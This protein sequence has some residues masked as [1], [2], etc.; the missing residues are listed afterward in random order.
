MGNNMRK[1][2]LLVAVT[3]VILAAG[4]KGPAKK[5]GEEISYPIA[6]IT[7]EKADIGTVIPAS[8]KGKQD[9]EIRPKVNGYIVKLCVDEGSVVRRGQVLFQLDPVSYQEAVAAAEALIKT[10]EANVSSLQLTVENKRILAQRNVISDMELKA[11]EYSM[12]SAE[13][14]LAQ[15]K[16]QLASAKKDLSYTSIVSPSNGVVGSI[17]YR[18]GSLAST[19]MADPLTVVSDISDIYAYF[20]IDEKLLL[21]YIR[22]AQEGNI[23]QVIKKMPKV[24]LMLADGSDYPIEGTIETISGVINS[25]TGSVTLRARFP[26]PNNILRS[27]GS[28]NIRI[29]NHLASAIF[30]PQKSTYELQNKR[31]VYMVT[32]SSTVR[33]T[34]IETMDAGDGQRFIVTS[35]LKVGSRIV[36]AGIASLHDGMKISIK[37]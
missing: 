10:V 20:S 23:N 6:T 31:F 15:A 3:F 1:D 26:N 5:Q 8:L 32:D 35:G 13:G 22:D 21:G 36:V 9:V 14:Q 25:E 16:A 27:G 19:T 24:K 33:S 11:A 28:G 18:V 7:A 29:P 2:I 30:I 34:P 4:C 37:K 12:K 17:V